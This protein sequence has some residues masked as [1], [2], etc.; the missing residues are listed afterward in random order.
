[1]EG[2]IFSSNISEISM[3][4]LALICV[5]FFSS[6][7]LSQ[8]SVVVSVTLN[9]MGDF[10]LKTSEV[11]GVALK[12][13][14]GFMAENIVVNL[15]SLKS[16][17]ELRDT[18]TQK[19]LKSKEFP[20]AVLIKARGKNGKGIAKIKIK[21]IEK[22]VR[23]TYK[24]INEGKFLEAQFPILISQYDIKDINYM[25]V[26]VEDEIQLKVVVPVQDGTSK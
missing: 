4:K 22:E 9:P 3:N 17:V 8:Q 25:G 19:Y 14:E 7:A 6:I 20:E 1:M 23:G 10:K 16:G 11:K 13:A 12:S 18:H 5:L 24:I 2:V 21:G 26:G 15:K